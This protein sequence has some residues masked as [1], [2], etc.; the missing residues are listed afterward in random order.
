MHINKGLVYA[1]SA[2]VW[3]GLVPI[4][5]KQLSHVDSIE[6]VMHRMV[7]ACVLVTALVVLMGQRRELMALFSQP[8]ILWR[9]FLA[10]SVISINWG[11]FIWAVNTGHMV[12][13]SMGYFI[14]P[15][16]SVAFG[17]L[18]FSECL[19]KGQMF[20]LA[21]AAS[22]VVYL[23]VAYGELPWISLVLASTFALYSLAK[24]TISVPA[25]HGMS[26]ET[27]FF[28]V[29]ALVYLSIIQAQG[30]GSFFDGPSN[31]WMLILGGLFTLIPLVLFAAA[32]KRVSMTVLGMS[33]Y[34]GPTLQL[35]IGVFLYNEPFGSERAI[36]F[37]L[38]WVA[39]FIYTFDQ[40]KY[41][42]QAKREQSAG[43]A[44]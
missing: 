7:W 17:V 25:T 21:I 44:R 8:K 34:I 3:W 28:F 6:I 42:R 18:V 4:F 37:G 33:Q 38:I 1:L 13:T 26:V 29:P 31:W 5:W 11:V 12:E 24:K 19:R 35:I 40:L 39:L 41:Q 32:A 22:A 43:I 36:A 23:I 14:N 15:L 9:L 30:D 27:L 20:A 10:S 2:Y 16:I